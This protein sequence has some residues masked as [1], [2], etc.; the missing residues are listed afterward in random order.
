MTVFE[1]TSNLL[2]WPRSFSETLSFLRVR[3]P[4]IGSWDGREGKEIID[5]SGRVFWAWGKG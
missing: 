3:P 1:S 4:K 2:E 5:L